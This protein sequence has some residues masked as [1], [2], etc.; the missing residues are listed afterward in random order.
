MSTALFINEKTAGFTVEP[1][2]TTTPLHT[3]NTQA[4]AI[5][6]AKKNYPD[7]PLHVARVRDLGDKRVPDHWRKA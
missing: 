4:E 2:H 5:A 3:A 1:A 7:A 6:W